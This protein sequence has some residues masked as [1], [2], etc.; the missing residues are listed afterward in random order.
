MRVPVAQAVH[1]GASDC[2]NRHLQSMFRYIGFGDH[3][4][5]GIPKI[6]RNWKEQQWRSPRLAE[7]AGL[8]LTLLELRMVSLFPEETLKI[9]D[10]LFSERFSALPALE[11]IILVTAA[12]EDSVSHSRIKE[13]STEHPK[14]IS[15]ALAH[16]VQG[17]MLIKQGETRGSTYYVPG[18]TLQED[19][20]AFCTPISTNSPDLGGNPLHK[21]E[22]PLHKAENPLHKAGDSLHTVEA[23]H[24]LQAKMLKVLHS[25][26]LSEMPRRL[27]PELMRELILGIC[28]GDF[29]PLKI[30]AGILKRDSI[31]LQNN[32]LTPMLGEGLLEL[33]YPEIKSHP[34]QGYRKK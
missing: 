14:D 8:E 1:G 27:R 12:A 11:R 17:K 16:L 18:K 30:L 28:N 33:K 4:G 31:A 23:M 25:S 3:A 24:F 7:D 5:S 19:L 34:A 10:A 15:A 22:N 6:Y 20:S 2:R 32:Y 26:G 9:L 21:A 13:M 29:L